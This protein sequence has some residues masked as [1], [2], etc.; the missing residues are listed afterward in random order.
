MAMIDDYA[1]L[2]SRL[3]NNPVLPPQ[4]GSRRVLDYASANNPFAAQIAALPQRI[5]EGLRPLSSSQRRQVTAVL[6]AALDSLGVS[7]TT[8]ERLLALSDPAQF[9]LTGLTKL[10]AKLA[11]LQLGV[12]HATFVS[13]LTAPQMRWLANYR[14]VRPDVE[15]RA[16]PT[17]ALRVLPVSA[18]LDGGGLLGDQV[19]APEMIRGVNSSTH[20]VCGVT[21]SCTVVVEYTE[22]G[23]RSALLS[24]RGASIFPAQFV[25]DV[26]APPDP[27][28]VT[29]DLSALR[30]RLILPMGTGAIGSR[31]ILRALAAPGIC[32]TA[33]GSTT[34]LIAATVIESAARDVLFD[35][36]QV[37]VARRRSLASQIASLMDSITRTDVTFGIASVLRK[38]LDLPSFVGPLAHMLERRMLPRFP[39]EVLA[40]IVVG[41]AGPRATTTFNFDGVPIACWKRAAD[42]S[43]YLSA[44]VDGAPEA[45][46]PLAVSSALTARNCTPDEPLLDCAAAIE[47]SPPDA[48]G[49]AWTDR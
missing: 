32:R 49:F 9:V 24:T 26:A 38:A 25:G 3:F 44:C 16:L 13:G 15:I 35:S 36:A 18:S 43:A 10:R 8:A 20:G 4:E 7:L 21:T 46:L 30:R 45:D 6:L 14:A 39:D 34:K 48:Q 17:Q 22:M 31:E 40:G 47:A 5:D 12:R 41:S 11:T 29:C 37:S 28:A 42:G 27:G 1:Q 23:A 19:A 2:A 33:A